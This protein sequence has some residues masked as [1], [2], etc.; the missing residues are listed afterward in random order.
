MKGRLAG[1]RCS[2]F[3]VLCFTLPAFFKE[4]GWGRIRTQANLILM[5]FLFI[6]LS[7]ISCCQRIQRIECEAGWCGFNVPLVCD[8]TKQS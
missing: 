2:V 4:E 6:I 3:R 5:L 7:F 8:M 1:G